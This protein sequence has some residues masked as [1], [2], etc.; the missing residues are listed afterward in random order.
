MRVEPLFDLAIS[1]LF[2][3]AVAFLYLARQ[4]FLV[5]F[6]LLQI[7]VGEFSP[8]FLHLTLEL[9]PVTGYLIPTQ[10]HCWQRDSGGQSGGKCERTLH[11]LNSWF[12]KPCCL[13]ERL[14]LLT[15]RCVSLGGFASIVSRMQRVRMGD[16]R[17]LSRL[18]MMSGSVL[19]SCFLVMLHS[20]LMMLSSLG[21]MTMGWM[22][23]LRWFLSHVCSPFLVLDSKK[24]PQS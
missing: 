21:V 12:V 2:R 24:G 6:R 19:R 8:L 10:G 22:T 3:N 1:F 11:N 14:L 13:R 23:D 16:V 18:L 20:L 15:V 9:L 7:V 4:Y 5:A 17:V